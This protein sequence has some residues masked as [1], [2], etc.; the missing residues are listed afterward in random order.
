MHALRDL[1]GLSAAHFSFGTAHSDI[2]LN[3]TVSSQSHTTIQQITY[4]PENTRFTKKA[5]IELTVMQLAPREY[6]PKIG[7]H[8]AT[9]SSVT[10]NM[11]VTNS[12]LPRWSQSR[13]T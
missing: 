10:I 1:M 7:S 5:R 4:L 6:S 8:F 3:P 2:E 12:P 13:G 9:G 11:K